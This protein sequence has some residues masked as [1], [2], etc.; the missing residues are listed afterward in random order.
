M[1]SI[2]FSPAS[3]VGKHEN[4]LQSA[5]ALPPPPS[6]LFGP[7]HRPPSGTIPLLLLLFSLL[8]HRIPF[9]F[10]LTPPSYSKVSRADR[11]PRADREL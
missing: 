4:R 6:L 2:A 11:Y 1:V 3:S 10:L 8:R 9:G 5:T 7:G